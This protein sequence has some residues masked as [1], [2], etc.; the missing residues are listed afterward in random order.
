[1]KSRRSTLAGF[2]AILLWSANVA[3]TRSISE[4]IGPALMGFT[5]YTAGGLMLAAGILAGG[6][7]FGLPEGRI[8]QPLFRGALVVVYLLALSIALGLAS[9]RLE[10]LE[11]GLLNYLWPTLTLIG[12]LFLLNRRA[13]VWLLPGTALA[14]AG[15]FL[16]FTQGASVTWA[17]FSTHILSNPLSY[18]LGLLAAVCWAGYS[19]LT[20]RWQATASVWDMPI[21]LTGG[22]LV[23]GLIALF[24]GQ[25]FPPTFGSGVEI[26]LLALF[27]AGGYMLWDAAMKDGDIVLVAAVS[28]L[29]PFFSTLVSVIYLNVH[30]G[31]SLWLG[32]LLIIAGSFVSWRSF[33][34]N[35]L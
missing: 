23:F 3:F 16:V 33:A 35:K 21:Y 22:G 8:H 27:T 32:C 25:N 26:L 5:V 28:Y 19:N 30:P 12:S 20:R 4:Q 7:R 24:K 10:A 14:L 13:G 15:I 29:T 1:M 9:G 17:S 31:S 2:A 34:P 18:A 11:I 6:R